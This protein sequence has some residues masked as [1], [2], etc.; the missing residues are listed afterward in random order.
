MLR[1]VNSFHESRSI[2]VIVNTTVYINTFVD[3]HIDKSNS[4]CVIFL[5]QQYMLSKS[6]ARIESCLELTQEHLKLD[7]VINLFRTGIGC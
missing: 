3:K 2:V 6:I 1:S 4:I 5:F 7:T